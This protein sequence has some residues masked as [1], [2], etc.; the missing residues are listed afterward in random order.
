[1]VSALSLTDPIVIIL[2]KQLTHTEIA[3][4]RFEFLRYQN[5]LRFYISVD[6]VVDMHYSKN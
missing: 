2:L 6:D 4:L 1:M 3:Q 5:I